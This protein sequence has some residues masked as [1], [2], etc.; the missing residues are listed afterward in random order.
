MT[1]DQL[2]KHFTASAL[3]IKD[4]KVLLVHHKKMG[5]WLYPGGHVEGTETP[6]EAL[7]REVKEET[8]LDVEILGERDENLADLN[9]N[10]S[11]LYNPYVVLCELVGDH[12]HNDMVYRCKILS[13]SSCELQHAEGESHGIKFFGIKDL[14][15]ISL[16]PNF[17]KL[18]LKIMSY[19]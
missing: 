11:V 10:V 7:I 13:D 6:D 1:N 18:L 2:K 12:Y 9:N 15:S 3:I 17:K 8:N 16:F 14:D 5:V 4:D 19:N